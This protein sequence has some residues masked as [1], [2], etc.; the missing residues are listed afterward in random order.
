MTSVLSVQDGQEIEDIY[1]LPGTRYWL[2]RVT[3]TRFWVYGWAWDG[4]RWFTQY[5]RALT[6][7]FGACVADGLD[8]KG[9]IDGGRAVI[10]RVHQE[11]N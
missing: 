6:G 11:A 9:M 8:A 5:Q 1:E 3:T 4:E 10:S 2:Q 7:I